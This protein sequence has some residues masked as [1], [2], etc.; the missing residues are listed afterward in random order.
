MS[1]TAPGS[2]FLE[3]SPNRE[4]ETFLLHL[5]DKDKLSRHANGPDPAFRSASPTGIATSQFH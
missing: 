3:D 2:R 4:T 5:P 1:E